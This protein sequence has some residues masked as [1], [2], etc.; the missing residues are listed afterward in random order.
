MDTK[1]K[2]TDFGYELDDYEAGIEEALDK[3]GFKSVPNVK[4]EI[5]R[6]RGYAKA[7][8]EK[9]K[10]IN[11]RI[12]QGDLFH[13]KSKAEKQGIPYQTLIS[14]LIHQYSNNKID[15]NVLREPRMPYKASKPKATKKLGKT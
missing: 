6:Y 8:L 4:Q 11:I 7:M 10:N 5:E 13:I 2:Q 3:G 12:S 14:S 15:Y 1:Y 9:T